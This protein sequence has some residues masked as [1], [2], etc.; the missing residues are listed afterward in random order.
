M[1]NHFDVIVLGTGL[2]ESI[3][4][5]ALSKAGF[6]VA[7][8]DPNPYYGA[9]EASLSLDELAQWVDQYKDDKTN[10][11]VSPRPRYRFVTCCEE[12]PPHAKQYSVSL[13]PSVIPS[14]GPFISS[15]IS[16]GVSRYG[17]FKLLGRVV[18]YDNGVVKDVPQSKDNIFQNKAMSLLE[19]RR[20]MRFLM[21]AGGDFESSEELQGLENSPFLDFLQKKFLLSEVTA[22]A[23]TYAL[24][25]CYFANEQTLPALHRIRTYLRAS[26]RYGSSSFLVGYY[27]GSG[28]IAQG[29]CRASAVGGAVYILGRS[30]TSLMSRDPA[31]PEHPVLTPDPARFAIEVDDFPERLHCQC[32]I[33][34]TTLLPEHLRSQADIIQPTIPSCSSP[35]PFAIARCIAIVDGSITLPSS[36]D[37][38]DSGNASDSSLL[39]FPPES[40]EGGSTKSA[41][42]VMTAGPGTMSAPAGK[43]ILYISMALPSDSGRSAEALLRP[44]LTA[45]L[46]LLRA[47]ETLSC[48]TFYMQELVSYAPT[49]T[50]SLMGLLAV[51]SLNP[52]LTQGVDEAAI[53]AEATF[54][55]AVACLHGERK[56]LF[57]QDSG[58][59]PSLAEMEENEGDD[60][61][62]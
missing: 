29:F 18:I 7:H 45:V 10:Q 42:H 62:W 12:V 22:R 52:H 27:G 28:E 59:W 6:K 26:G 44:Y 20:L 56:A 17:S 37:S 50:D 31:E 57:D 11:T 41:V 39:V 24:A 60:I 25:Y 40:L 58:F 32:L 19:K 43:G 8:I 55:K 16:S 9:D 53:A 47:E 36:L 1:D 5:A 54:W 3:T 34:S 23:I 35:Q 51:P 2:T 38:E 46:A 30:V 4:A 14:V 33:S 21:F 48:S 61:Q 49:T 13:S 15:L